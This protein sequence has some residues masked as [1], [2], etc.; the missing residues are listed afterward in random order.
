MVGTNHVS[1]R[2][3]E[4]VETILRVR[5]AKVLVELCESRAKST[6]S[7]KKPSWLLVVGG[8]LE[9]I[10]V[11][12]PG[13]R[14]AVAR[15]LGLVDSQGGDMTT[16]META[17]TVGAEVILADVDFDETCRKLRG[18]LAPSLAKVAWAVPDASAMRI[19]TEAV[20]AGRNAPDVDEAVDRATKVL[21]RHNNYRI[22]VS[23]FETMLPE[24]Y[25][26][27]VHQRDQRLTENLQSA[28]EGAKGRPV[29]CVVGLAHV[30]GIE[31]RFLSDDA[32][33]NY[34]VGAPDKKNN[35]KLFN[36]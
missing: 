12:S 2:S 28:V 15:A 17:E 22:V 5:P 16:A 3:R 27:L 14:E 4:E 13:M 25:D 19:V 29:V 35:Y 31:K 11:T 24:L 10:G 1:K 8:L 6:K 26:V 7:N 21:E 9:K 36:S 20:A 33:I 34:I 18:V 30:D 32:S 23:A